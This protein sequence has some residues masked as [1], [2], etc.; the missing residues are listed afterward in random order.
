MFLCYCAKNCQKTPDEKSPRGILYTGCGS[1]IDQITENT[2]TTSLLPRQFFE[3]LNFNKKI[4]AISARILTRA[5]LK[6]ILGA[7]RTMR[8]GTCNLGFG[9]RLSWH[10]QVAEQRE[11]HRMIGNSSHRGF[12]HEGRVQEFV[13]MRHVI[14]CAEC[15]KARVIVTFT[16]GPNREFELRK[17]DPWKDENFDK[18]WVYK[19]AHSDSSS[20][21]PLHHL[22][23][24]PS[25]PTFSH[26]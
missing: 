17:F 18:S 21:L 24:G 15:H 16:P 4:F 10:Q 19:R 13:T 2:W 20:G 5:R 26:S 9:G 23:L 25:L 22:S 6:E 11:Y 3:R 8:R 14:D 7:K 12:G 1:R